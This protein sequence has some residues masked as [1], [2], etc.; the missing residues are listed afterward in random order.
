MTNQELRLGCL[1]VAKTLDENVSVTG[2]SNCKY[3]AACIEY[4][5]NLGNSIDTPVAQK[6]ETTYE[7][8]N[9]DSCSEDPARI[10]D[11]G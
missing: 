6:E 8:C 5:E 3:I 10:P 7:S 2:K 11:D 4:L 1:S 9:E